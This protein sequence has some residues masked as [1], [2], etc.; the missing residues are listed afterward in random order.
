MTN[1][2]DS[3]L[4]FRLKTKRD[5]EAFARIYDRYVEA[6]YRFVILKLPSQEEAQD[7]TAETF[8][9]TWQYVNEN[10]KITNIRAFLYRIARNLV[11]DRYRNPENLQIDRS[12]TFGD[13]N[14]SSIIEPSDQE[15]GKRVVEA[16]ADLSLVLQKLERLKEDYRD[17]LTLRL[18]DDLPFGVIAE[19]LEKNIGNVRVIYHRAL[20][21]LKEIE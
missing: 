1:L 21:A 19:I 10:K 8:T 12:V 2:I 9:R 18:I 5:P 13:E 4:L 6:I 16:R 7:V 11:A 3:Y 20:K 17:V 15:H 14:T